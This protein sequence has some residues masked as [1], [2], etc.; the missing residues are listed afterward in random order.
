MNEPNKLFNTVDHVPMA[1][2]GD[3]DEPLTGNWEPKPDTIAETPGKE[4]GTGTGQAR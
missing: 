3:A 4:K 2:P 1:T